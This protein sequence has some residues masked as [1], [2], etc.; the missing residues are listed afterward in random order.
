MEIRHEIEVL[1]KIRTNINEALGFGVSRERF[2]I[3]LN[4]EGC[5]EGTFWPKREDPMSFIDLSENH[6]EIFGP[7]SRIGWKELYKVVRA[8]A[9]SRTVVMPDGQTYSIEAGV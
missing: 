3:W 5:L 7:G 1:R 9:A 6:W 4:F 8:L 2:H